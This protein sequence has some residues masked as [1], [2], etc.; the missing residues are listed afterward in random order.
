VILHLG[1]H[2]F[3]AT[4]SGECPPAAGVI[5]PANRDKSQREP[6]FA[7]ASPVWQPGAASPPGAM[8]GSP[9]AAISRSQAAM[10]QA[11]L[12]NMS[13]S[14]HHVRIAKNLI[15]KGDENLWPETGF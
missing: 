5:R 9:L 3:R 13:D 6:G 8:T 10:Y 15:R 4:A 12:T 11:V 1:L 2:L 7:D 14:G